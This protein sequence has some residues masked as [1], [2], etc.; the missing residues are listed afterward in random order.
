MKKILILVLIIISFFFWQKLK[1]QSQSSSLPEI[2]ISAFPTLKP[3]PPQTVEISLAGKSFLVS[4]F[5]VIDTSKLFLFSNLEEKN[6]ASE[7]VDKYKCQALTSAGFYDKSDKPLGLFISEGKAFRNK[8]E[9]AL[10][11]GF[12]LVKTTGE[13]EISRFSNGENLRLGLQSGPFL[14]EDENPVVLHINNDE[15]ARRI[16][17]LT[18]KD[19]QLYFLAVYNSD[20]PLQGPYLSDLPNILLQFKNKTNVAILNALNLDGGS[21]S[22]FYDKTAGLSFPEIS[23]IGSFFCIR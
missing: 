23:I 10:F 3:T 15:F 19:K 20:S 14:W 7:L 1:P 8:L 17:I 9:S 18:T 22:A 2:P 16:V 5:K 6:T 4:F 13:F 21:A 12:F 11:N